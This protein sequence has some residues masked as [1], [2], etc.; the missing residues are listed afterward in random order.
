MGSGWGIGG[1]VKLFWEHMGKNLWLPFPT[2]FPTSTTEY[3]GKGGE[4]RS[5]Q[6]G[7]SRGFPDG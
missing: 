7:Y 2:V 5:P 6:N 3:T 1:E 4:S